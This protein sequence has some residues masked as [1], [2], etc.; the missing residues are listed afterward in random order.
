MN[1]LIYLKHKMQ[2]YL[3]FKKLLYADL[4]RFSPN[5]SQI[6]NLNEYHYSGTHL[7]AYKTQC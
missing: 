1:A 3:F 6:L 4:F 5:I 7:T 2:K